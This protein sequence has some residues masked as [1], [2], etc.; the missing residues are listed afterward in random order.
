MFRFHF[1]IR[2]L[3]MAVLVLGVALAVLQW[4]SA[5]AASATFTLLLALLALGLTGAF[6]RR[7]A[8]RAFWIGFFVFGWFYAEAA[9]PAASGSSVGRPFWGFLAQ[10][11]YPGQPQKYTPALLTDLLFDFASVNSRLQVGKTVMAQ[12]RSGGYYEATIIEINGGQYLARWTDGSAP[13]WVARNQIE[14]HNGAGQQAAHSVIAILA[15]LIGGALAEMFFTR[16]PGE[17]SRATP[18]RE[19][20][21]ELTL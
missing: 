18:S 8:A 11:S 1:S 5:I 2:H 9:S 16:E 10:P 3:L 7:G 13:S 4:D 12:W 6:C 20:D 19:P 21:R 14:L 15:A 17:R